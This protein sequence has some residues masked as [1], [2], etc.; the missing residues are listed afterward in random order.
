MKVVRTRTG[1]L[2]VEL[3]GP[4][5]AFLTTPEQAEDGFCVMKGIIPPGAAVPLHSHAD[6]EDFYVLSGSIEY[7]RETAQGLRWEQV[8]TGDF[9]H[10]PPNAKHAWRNLSSEPVTNL[11]VTT[12]KMARFFL[13]VGR[14][15]TGTPQPV[16]PEDLERFAAISARYGYWNATP[17]ENARAGLQIS[18]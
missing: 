9:I 3:F 1:D 14:P 4:T 7:L 18:F 8:K 15:V 2:V 5:M 16:S 17:E 10:V 13:E 12:D 11:I 6:T